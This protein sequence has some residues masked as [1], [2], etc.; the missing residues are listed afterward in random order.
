MLYPKEHTV[1]G[2]EMPNPGRSTFYTLNCWAFFKEPT[3]KN[4]KPK[5][6]TKKGKLFGN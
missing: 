3:K 5:N 4:L 6:K 1:C 2:Q